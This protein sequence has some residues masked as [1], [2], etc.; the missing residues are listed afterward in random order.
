MDVV[1]AAIASVSGTK[2]AASSDYQYWCS[3]FDLENKV[4]RAVNM[5]NGQWMSSIATDGSMLPV[6][7]VLA[8]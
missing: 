1:N 2:V 5:N 4:V 8:F 6:R 3:T 7:V